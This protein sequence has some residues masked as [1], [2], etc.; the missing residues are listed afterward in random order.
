LE[1]PENRNYPNDDMDEDREFVDNMITVGALSSNYGS[2]MVASFSN[3]GNQRVD[4]FAPGAEIYSTMPD[5]DY[6]FQGGT[7]MAAPAVAGVAALIRSFH[8]DLSASQVK[9]IIMQ[10]GL[11]TKASVIVA[12]DQTKATTFDKISK[13]GKMVNAYNALI[14]A[15]N[16]SNGKMTLEKNSK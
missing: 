11:R 1:D 12:G 7:S 2:E 16:I 4:V 13:S 6:E 10:S 9:N 15:N 14:L 3:Y 5:N 8:P